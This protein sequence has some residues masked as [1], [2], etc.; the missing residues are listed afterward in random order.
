MKTHKLALILGRFQG[1]HLGH[2]A[3]IQTAFD[4]AEKVIILIGSAQEYRTSKNPLTYLERKELLAKVFPAAIIRPI[5]DIGVGNNSNWGDYVI[6][7]VKKYCDGQVPDLII[8]GEE[9][10][11]DTWFDNYN[12]EHISVPKVF[13]ISGTQMRKYALTD[14]EA[15]CR[16]TPNV[17]WENYYDIKE[18]I[19]VSTENETKSI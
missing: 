13:E 5:P 16:F 6:E 12:I 19:S 17:I 11:R 8:T 2:K 7:T 4:N 9:E 14:K 3:M 1:L 15:W 10:R 18:I